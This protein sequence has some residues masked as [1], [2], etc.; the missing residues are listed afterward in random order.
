MEET[1]EDTATLS[2]AGGGKGDQ[3]RMKKSDLW[4]GCTRLVCGV[5]S[6]VSGRAVHEGRY[7]VVPSPDKNVKEDARRSFDNPAGVRR[8]CVWFRLEVRAS[9]SARMGHK[10]AQSK[11]SNNR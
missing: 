1:A 9:L 4:S 5:I 3:S 10:K 7:R 2:R 11:E 6:P 8:A